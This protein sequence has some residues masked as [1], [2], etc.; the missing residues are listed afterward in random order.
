VSNETERE[1][2]RREK[3]DL[4]WARS[5]QQALEESLGEPRPGKPLVRVLGVSEAG[6][7]IEIELRFVSGVRYCCA[8]PECHLG[9]GERSW[10]AQLRSRLRDSTDR[11]PPPLSLPVRGV[12]EDGAVLES[13]QAVGLPARSPGYVFAY[14]PIREQDAR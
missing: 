4:G 10:W 12:V 2:H 8:E 9:L 1:R 13:L 3:R 7:H 6:T 5:V 14:G 11:D